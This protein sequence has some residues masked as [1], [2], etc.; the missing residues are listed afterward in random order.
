MFKQAE[1]LFSEKRYLEAGGLYEQLLQID[2][3]NVEVLFKLSRVNGALRR[4]GLMDHLLQRLLKIQPLHKDGN[5]WLSKAMIGQGQMAQAAAQLNKLLHL[6]GHYGE[7]WN[8]LGQIHQSKKEFQE[9][10][11]CYVN[12]EACDPDSA[13]VQT[14]LG[15]LFIEAGASDKARER[16]DK[17]FQLDPDYLPAAL[18]HCLLQPIIAKNANEIIVSRKAYEDGLK[19]LQSKWKTYRNNSNLMEELLWPYSFYLAYQGLEDRDV[20]I[21]WSEFFE[22]LVAKALPGIVK[23]PLRI[24]ELSNRKKIRV[25]YIT[26]FFYEHTVSQYFKSWI[27]QADYEEFE[28]YCYQVDGTSNDVSKSLADSCT[29][30]RHLTGTI[31]S[32]GDTLRDDQLDILVYLEIGMYRKI[33]WLAVGRYAPV[34]CVAWGHPVTTGLSSIEYFI[35]SRVTEP[36]RA[37]SHYSETLVELDGLG[38]NCPPRNTV[39]N[40][41]RGDFGLPEGKNLYLC[42]QSLFKIHPDSD[43]LFARIATQD[44]D[45][46]IIFVENEMLPIMNALKKRLKRCFDETGAN[47][48]TQVQ[49][50][51]RMGPEKYS[52]LNQ[53]CAVMLDTPHWSGGMTSL[54]AFANGLP[55]V[56]QAGAQS[57]GRQ[58]SGMYQIMGLL[59]LIADGTDSYVALATKL[60]NDPVLREKYSKEI[61]ERSKQYLFNNSEGLYSLEAFYKKVSPRA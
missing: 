37:Q 10:H 8:L 41:L 44:S 39:E 33:R 53:I 16:Y 50:V 32:M 52:H 25:G 9:A 18:G 12:A 14:K 58:T 47:Y 26:H 3:D 48:E 1:K 35:S 45:A 34:Q 30:Y 24:T 13:D 57:R 51:P 22:P 61:V 21:K 55:I 38:V 4:F 29:Q 6:D 15:S 28:V 43:G 56:T 60:G 27:E 7:A 23:S 11:H 2:G 40:G 17:A 31:E 20:Q 59:D 19:Y 5:Y 42:P 46:L 49:F 36:D 54:D